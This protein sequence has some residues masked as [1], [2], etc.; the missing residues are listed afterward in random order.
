MPGKLK[1]GMIG[2]GRDSFIGSVHRMAAGLDGHCE[3]VCGVFS[4]DPERSKAE[5]AA[6]YLAPERLYATFEEMI[7]AESRMPRGERMDFVAIVVPNHLHFDMARLALENGFAVVCDKPMTWNLE[8]ARRLEA[9]VDR[10]GLLFAL[11]HNYTGY[12]LVKEARDMVRAGKLGT[13]RKV[14]VEYPQGSM[15]A[16]VEAQGNKRAAWRN[17][18]MRSGAAMCMADIGTHAENLAEYI[19]G[20]KIV[21]LCADLSTFVEGRR[22]DDDGSVLLRFDNGAR[23]ILEASKISAGEGNAL[24]IRVYG[25]TGGLEWHQQQPNTLLFKRMNRPVEIHQAGAGYLSEVARRNAR[26]PMGHPEGFIEA[27]ANI[28]RNFLL[29]LRARLEGRD[30]D[31]RH[32]D[33]PTVRDGVRGMAF[34]TAVVES[35]QSEKKWTRFEE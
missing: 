20:L 26:L 2:G 6:L 17:D 14:I 12:P 30:P 1:M 4:S 7:R 27:F 33:F 24:H 23:G 35:S 16:P 18:P 34:I 21:E 3:L 25:E 11:M 13:I 15:A 32:L 10:S 5:G 22:L 9:M 31:P 28:Y 19:T 29:S 8:Q